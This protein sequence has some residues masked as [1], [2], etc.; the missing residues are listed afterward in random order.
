MRDMLLPS[1]SNLSHNPLSP[2][3]PSLSSSSPSVATLT[4]I[5]ST[6]ISTL[7]LTLPPEESSPL[8]SDNHSILTNSE[9][10]LSSESPSRSSTCTN[11]SVT[12]SPDTSN[13]PTDSRPI[14][15]RRTE[16][17]IKEVREPVY[18]FFGSSYPP[19]TKLIALS[20]L[21]YLDG[22]SLYAMSCVNHLWC[23]AVMDDALWE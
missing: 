18:P 22:P 8:K 20:C 5:P 1:V 4:T 10:D 23:Q 7:T 11:S 19:T 16:N 13:N 21:E 12:E 9:S 3:H 6:S 14:K 17:G 15:K 2:H